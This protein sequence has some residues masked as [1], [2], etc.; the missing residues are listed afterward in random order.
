MNCNRKTGSRATYITRSLALSVTLLAVVQV[1]QILRLM[2]GAVA[3]VV[4][5]VAASVA[6]GVMADSVDTVTVVVLTADS[7]A[8][9]GDGAMAL[10]PAVMVTERPAAI[11]TS[12]R[13]SP[14]TRCDLVPI[15]TI[16]GAT[17]RPPMALVPEEV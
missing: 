13:K 7:M 14:K 11:S 5:A 16:T 9:T 2:P 6:D 12:I 4:E 3:V 15:K 10:Q 8:A 1:V 17:R